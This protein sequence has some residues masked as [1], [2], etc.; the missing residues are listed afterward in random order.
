MLALSFLL[1]IG[2]MLIADVVGQHISKGYVYFAMCFS[3]FVEIQFA[4]QTDATRSLR[5][6]DFRER[7]GE[8]H[9]L[10]FRAC[11]GPDFL[12]MEAT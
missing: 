10:P 6:A 3:V 8:H 4:W 11:L 1:L 5:I 7:E 9:C 12:R 2:V